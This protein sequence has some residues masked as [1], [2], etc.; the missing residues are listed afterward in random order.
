M[1]VQENIEKIQTILSRGNYP[2]KSIAK[3][4]HLSVDQV[5]RA[6]KKGPFQ[7]GGP[8]GY[9]ELKGVSRPEGQKKP[10]EKRETIT[11]VAE[12]AIKAGKTNDEVLQIL[13][14]QFPDFDPVKKKYYPT[15]YRSKLNREKKSAR[16]K[17]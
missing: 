11:S 17:K 14:K 9:W 1:S 12:S 7:P 6:L 8:K 2:V 13:V 15:W 16:S 10:K 5:R 4:A 3:L